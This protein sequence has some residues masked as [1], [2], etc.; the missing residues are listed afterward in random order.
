MLGVVSTCFILCFDWLMLLFTK[1]IMN[2][3]QQLNITFTV[4]VMRYSLN[5][6]RYCM[7]RISWFLQKGY[8]GATLYYK[9]SCIQIIGIDRIYLILTEF[10]DQ[11][12]G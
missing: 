1:F 11:C 5:T 6:L 3:D 8:T 4:R 2:E 7:S 9:G 12:E 10:T